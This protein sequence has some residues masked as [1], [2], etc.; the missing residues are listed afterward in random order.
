M[1][2]RKNT[3]KSKGGAKKSRGAKERP[4]AKRACKKKGKKLGAYAG[5]EHEKKEK[6]KK[7]DVG[8]RLYGLR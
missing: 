3:K 7:R 6:T 5:G 8:G 1:E 2:T 4:D